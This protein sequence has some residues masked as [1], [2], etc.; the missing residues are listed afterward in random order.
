MRVGASSSGRRP[1]GE[2]S[3]FLDE[4][5]LTAEATAVSGKPD[6]YEYDLGGARGGALARPDGAG[7]RTG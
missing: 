7:G 6:L 3:F 4:R 5:R 2:R 1:D